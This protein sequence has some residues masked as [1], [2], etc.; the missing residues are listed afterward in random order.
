[1]SEKRRAPGPGYDMVASAN[2][3]N[4]THTTQF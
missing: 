2:P 3:L 1:M 4:L